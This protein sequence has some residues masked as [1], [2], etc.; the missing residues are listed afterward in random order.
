M[1]CAIQFD[2]DKPLIEQNVNAWSEMQSLDEEPAYREENIKSVED[3]EFFRGYKFAMDD[4]CKILDN[5]VV[6]NEL[7]NKV[8]EEIQRWMSGDLCMHLFSILDN[9]PEDDK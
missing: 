6:D 9:Q 7:T 3:K 4:V 2:E 5:F 1:R 8:S